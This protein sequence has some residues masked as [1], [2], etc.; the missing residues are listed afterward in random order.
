M[1]PPLPWGRHPSCQLAHARIHNTC[2]KH[3]A[4]R[5]GV[6]NSNVFR[7][8]WLKPTSKRNIVATKES[9]PI[10]RMSSELDQKLFCEIMMSHTDPCI[11]SKDCFLWDV[12]SSSET[13]RVSSRFKLIL[14]NRRHQILVHD[15]AFFKQTRFFFLSG[16]QTC[17]HENHDFE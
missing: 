7:A 15:L 12:H 17:S 6:L 1:G 16:V 13:P 11:L 9:L 5:R 3:F 4:G 8:R 2:F 10:T 14:E